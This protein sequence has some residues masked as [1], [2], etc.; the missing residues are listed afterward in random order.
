VSRSTAL[1][2]YAAGKAML[3]ESEDAGAVVEE[4]SELADG[5]STVLMDARD[6]LCSTRAEPH[7]IQRATL[8]IERAITRIEQ[9]QRAHVTS[10]RL[11]SSAAETSA[12]SQRLQR[13][14]SD[15][16]S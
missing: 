11:R 7:R 5:D 10:E 8:L 6:L 3:G 16:R 4:L 13:S 2:A 12:S 1:A 9:Q 15:S 14:C